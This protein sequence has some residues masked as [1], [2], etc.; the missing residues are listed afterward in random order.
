MAT[1]RSRRLR[2]KLCV[3]EFQELGFELSFQYQAGQSEEAVEA[4]IQ[5]FA[6]D[7][8]QPNDLVYS[9]CDEYGFICLAQRGSVNEQQRGL[10]E[11]WLKQQPELASFSVGPLADA[12]YP[13]QP[14]RAPEP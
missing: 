11:D 10:I 2:K 8:V 4:F 12:W 14:V 13:D 5:R 9:G 6:N 1:Q 7:A 3:D